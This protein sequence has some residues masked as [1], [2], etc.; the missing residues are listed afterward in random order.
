MVIEQVK[1]SNPRHLTAGRR[2][3]VGLLAVLLLGGSM[4]GC[5]GRFP[6]TNSVYRWN[7]RATN[8]HIVNSIIMIVF[9]I[10]PVY[11]ICILVDAIIIN[12]IEYWDGKEVDIAHTY[13]QPDG[14]TVV[15]SPGVNKGE[16]ILTL[17]R[18]DVLIAQ[19]TFV[20]NEAGVTTVYNE[21][22]E[23][24]SHVT[25]DGRK[26]FLFTDANHK[27][28]GSLTAD[29]IAELKSNAAAESLLAGSAITANGG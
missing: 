16:A 9:A 4:S 5:Y 1:L 29:Q 6:L 7:G 17:S 8:N 25:P 11:G 24:V 2:I 10:F 21:R 22:N 18:A 12:S 15:L 20:R 3:I 19:R 27:P 26:G 23:V 28:T 14:T 13:Q